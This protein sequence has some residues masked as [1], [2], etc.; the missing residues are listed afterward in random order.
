MSLSLA[1]IENAINAL[2]KHYRSVVV[3]LFG[4]GEY[5]LQ[6]LKDCL[7]KLNLLNATSVA[8]IVLY[9]SGDY[10]TD[11]KFQEYI[12]DVLK[13][14]STERSVL[15]SP[16]SLLEKEVR[17][18]FRS[19]QFLNKCIDV[20]YETPQKL[21]N[22]L[23][24]L[25]RINGE[26]ALIPMRNHFV[27]AH[28]SNI[29]LKLARELSIPL[30]KENLT[31]AKM[32]SK[33]F[34]FYEL[35]LVTQDLW[36]RYK[37][38]LALVGGYFIYALGGSQTGSLSTEPIVYLPFLSPSESILS[39]TQQFM[40]KLELMA[41]FLVMVLLLI[42]N[43][44]HLLIQP[45]RNDSVEKKEKLKKIANIFYIYLLFTISTPLVSAFTYLK[46]TP[47]P[48]Q[49]ALVDKNWDK[50]NSL[51]EDQKH[52]SDEQ[53]KFVQAQILIQQRYDMP[54]GEY[55]HKLKELSGH[56]LNEFALGRFSDH[57]GQSYGVKNILDAN[58]IEN[59]LVS[60]D[61]HRI[62]LL[63][64]IL[65]LLFIFVSLFREADYLG[66]R[67]RKAARLNKTSNVEINSSQKV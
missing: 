25:D 67:K 48:I 47:S 29:L 65:C 14:G 45:V 8:S 55:E 34:S 37:Y 18:V 28:V 12:F 10:Q 24:G 20:G 5:R 54:Q 53:T 50:A 19:P 16:A 27:Q 30:S 62:V 6:K 52:W 35:K 39:V 9:K 42:G 61:M 60:Y 15:D 59:N 23:L 1:T 13:K 46:E 4:N 64:W 7:D 22:L 56:V 17:T 33:A 43:K 21:T 26:Q 51:V 3:Y 57:Y 36:S 63:I 58:N 2:P 40:F 44:F 11:S 31:L 41:V 49:T 32:F 38:I 66:L